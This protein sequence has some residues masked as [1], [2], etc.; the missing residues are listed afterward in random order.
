M[1]NT[2]YSP[3]ELELDEA[4]S[5][6]EEVGVGAGPVDELELELDAPITLR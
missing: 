5:E 3:S 4:C 2:T 6:L 1:V